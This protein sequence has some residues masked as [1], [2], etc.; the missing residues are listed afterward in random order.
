MKRSMKDIFLKLMLSILKNCMNVITIF[1][2]NNKKLVAN[3]HDEI[4]EIL[5][6][7]QQKEK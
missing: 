5:N 1:T 4:C 7:S 6:L 2:C 3:L